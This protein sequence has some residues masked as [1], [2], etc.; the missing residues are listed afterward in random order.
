[1]LEI[2]L[3]VSAST[4]TPRAVFVGIVLGAM[5][6]SCFGAAMLG[7]SDPRLSKV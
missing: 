3:R 1:M 4:I 5:E 2:F 6:H 7:T